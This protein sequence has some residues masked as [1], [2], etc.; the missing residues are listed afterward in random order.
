MIYEASISCPYYASMLQQKFCA[1]ADSAEG[2]AAYPTAKYP[3]AWER[4]LVEDTSKM[5][6]PDVTGIFS[7]YLETAPAGSFIAQTIN[8]RAP[9]RTIYDTAFATSL[10]Q[11]SFMGTVVDVQPVFSS[12]TTCE[13]GRFN[14]VDAREGT[15]VTGCDPLSTRNIFTKDWTN[16]WYEVYRV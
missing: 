16:I 2:W 8:E 11:G 12:C 4:P 9:L 3:F 1:T 5:M 14:P 13:A 10:R 15:N 6:G 7:L